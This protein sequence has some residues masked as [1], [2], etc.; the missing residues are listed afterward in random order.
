[1][2]LVKVISYSF[3]VRLLG[4][5]LNL[6]IFS[7]CLFLFSTLHANERQLLCG[8]DEDG[9]NDYRYCACIP[10]NEM[11]AENPWCLD[12]D[13]LLCIPLSQNPNC[14]PL[15]IHKTQGECLATIFQSEPRP[16]CSLVSLDFC[17][18]NH[19]ALCNPEGQ[20]ESC[21]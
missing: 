15:F 1:M 12:F 5:Y 11:E 3:L 6:V 7:G 20:P 10:Y 8:S 21:R 2:P 19:I 9:C 16:A 4:N 14:Y 13:R 17:H 18:E